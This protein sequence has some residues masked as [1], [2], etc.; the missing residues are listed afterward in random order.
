MCLLRPC[1]HCVTF[2]SYS[3]YQS[4]RLHEDIW[5]ILHIHI[6]YLVNIIKAVIIIHKTGWRSMLSILNLV[7]F[8]FWTLYFSHF[9]GY[10]KVA[11]YNYEIDLDINRLLDVCTTHSTQIYD[12]KWQNTFAY[13][14]KQWFKWKRIVFILTMVYMKTYCFHSIKYKRKN[15]PPH[16]HNIDIK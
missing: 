12:I 7:H 11:I 14:Q 10:T 5:C 3:S 8:T 9:Q 13:W 4:Y 15:T 6:L 2:T 16:K 1:F